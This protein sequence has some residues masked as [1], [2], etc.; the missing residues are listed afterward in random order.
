[1]TSRPIRNGGS[2]SDEVRSRIENRRIASEA[3]GPGL[4]YPENRRGRPEEHDP[5]IWNRLAADTVGHRPGDLP[6][7]LTAGRSKLHPG[8]VAPAAFTD[9][10]V[11]IIQ[12]PRDRVIIRVPLNHLPVAVNAV[13]SVMSRY[14][15]EIESSTER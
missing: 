15:N 3:V 11:G 13:L 2:H 7:L 6:G 4:R 9:R 14:L 12:T 10:G 5:R 8:Q 1:M